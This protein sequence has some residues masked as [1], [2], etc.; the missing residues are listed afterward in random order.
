[1]LRVGWAWPLRASRAL[2][3]AAA[4]APQLPTAGAL[5]GCTGG[6]RPQRSSVLQRR[7]DAGAAE[8]GRREVAG[9]GSAPAG[10]EPVRYGPLDVDLQPRDQLRPLL[11]TW[12]PPPTRQPRPDELEVSTRLRF[13]LEDR[14]WAA[15][16]REVGEDQV[17]VGYDGWPS[18]H[19]EWVPRDSDRLY[20]HESTHPDYT[21]PPVPQRFQRPVATDEEGNPLPPTPRPPR[22]RAYDPEKER[23]KRALRPPLPYNPE[24]ER[25]KRLLRGQS[26]PPMEP[27][28][29]KPFILPDFGQVEQEQPAVHEETSSISSV[30]GPSTAADA[31]ASPAAPATALADSAATSPA[32]PTAASTEAS[33][34]ASPAASA[35]GPTRTQATS[36]AQ[37]ASR[38]LAAGGP[39]PQAQAA[40]GLLVE[41][42][43]VPGG[44][45]GS[46]SFRH[47]ASGEVLKGPPPSGWVQVIA[48]GGNPYYWHVGR[49]V[50]QWE[51]P[52]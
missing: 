44:V 51:A 36:S 43:E 24:K 29:H 31:A 14:W 34:A 15:T 10:D 11:P 5:R 45:E 27:Q 19:D 4:S 25:L 38:D 2:R 13:R 39:A 37:G 6:S 26:V 49:Q 40:A 1:M 21:A 22:P 48:N 20:L 12:N 30:A 17:K 18:R 47:A 8:P 42:I 23:L 32:A 52:Q 33:A 28:D 41:W 9:A 3:V 46:R 16:V 35:A 50:T 7:P